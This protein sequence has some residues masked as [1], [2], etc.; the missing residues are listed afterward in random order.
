MGKH[1]GRRTLIHDET[2]HGDLSYGVHQRC[3]LRIGVFRLQ[4]ERRDLLRLALGDR[5]PSVFHDR[6]RAVAVEERNF[7]LPH[8]RIRT[9]A[10][11]EFEAVRVASIGT[12]VHVLHLVA[13]QLQLREFTDGNARLICHFDYPLGRWLRDVVLEFI[14]RTVRVRAAN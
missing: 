14:V 8:N 3:R 13:G 9:V 7:K 5:Q 4:F 11:L 6:V 10:H 2:I 1:H 12:R